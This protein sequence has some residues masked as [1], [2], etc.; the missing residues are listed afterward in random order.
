MFRKTK[1][2][3][4]VSMSCLVL[5]CVLIFLWL[6]STMTGKSE[7]AINDVGKIYM[8]EMSTQLQQKFDAITASWVSQ[9]EGIA[10]RTPP[11]E[12]VYGQAM[13]DDLALGASVREFEYLG[14]YTKD[15]EYEDVYGTPVTFLNEQE[16]HMVI[17]EEDRKITKIGRASCRE[18]V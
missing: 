11:Q 15:G 14:L 1:R 10:K 13:L 6:S 9:V 3:L 8:S 12:Q 2:F 5:L 17:G 7:E 4:F 16:F 18:R